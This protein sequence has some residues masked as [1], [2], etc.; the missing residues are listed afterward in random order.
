MSFQKKTI[1]LKIGLSFYSVWYSIQKNLN[2]TKTC[3]I[4]PIVF[5]RRKNVAKYLLLI[6][7]I[8]KLISS[9]SSTKLFNK[10][11]TDSW[12]ITAH[13]TS[14][15]LRA[16]IPRNMSLIV[17]PLVLGSLC[18]G[19]FNGQPDVSNPFALDLVGVNSTAESRSVTLAILLVLFG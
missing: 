14:S 3:H 2:K 8:V 17:W 4:K 19:G 9:F 11:S 1:K 5:P 15:F 12:T 7:S 16:T 13:S 10:H 6:H 18:I